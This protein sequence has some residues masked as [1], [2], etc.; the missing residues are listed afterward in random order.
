MANNKILKKIETGIEISKHQGKTE[1][2]HDNLIFLERKR[3]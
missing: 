1:I 2:L 3:Q